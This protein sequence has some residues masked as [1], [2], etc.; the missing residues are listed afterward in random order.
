MSNL[1]QF[2]RVEC[3][4]RRPSILKKEN[5]GEGAPWSLRDVL[6]EVTRQP[7]HHPHVRDPLPPVLLHGRPAQEVVELAEWRAGV[8][9]DAVDRHVRMDAPIAVC[10]VVSYP[11][12]WEEVRASP[13][14]T[15]VYDAWRDRSVEFL[16]QRTGGLIDSILLHEDEPYP[17]L[18]GLGAVPLVPG[19]T[20]KGKAIQRLEIGALD[21]ARTARDQAERAGKPAGEAARAAYRDLAFAYSV[22]V[23]LETGLRMPGL[24]GFGRRRLSSAGH[25]K[26]HAREGGAEPA[27][28]PVRPDLS[29]DRMLVARAALARLQAIPDLRAPAE[30]LSP[31]GFIDL[32]PAGTV[33]RGRVL[34]PVRRARENDR[35]DEAAEAFLDAQARQKVEAEAAIRRADDA[36]VRLAAAEPQASRL[37]RLLEA[38]SAAGPFAGQIADALEPVAP[39]AAGVVRRLGAALTGAVKDRDTAQEEAQRERERNARL[40]EETAE[41]KAAQAEAE[42]RWRALELLDGSEVDLD[43]RLGKLAAVIPRTAALARQ[44]LASSRKTVDDLRAKLSR[45][46][47]AKEQVERQLA[48]A[49]SGAQARAEAVRTIEAIRSAD[50]LSKSQGPAPVLAALGSLAPVLV[51]N[52]KRLRNRPASA[53]AG[54]AEGRR[55]LAAIEAEGAAL[56]LGPDGE[57]DRAGVPAAR[58]D[59]LVGHEA[60]LTL[61]VRERS[62]KAQLAALVKE[63]AVQDKVRAG[64]ARELERAGQAI[65]ARIS[66]GT[67]LEP[68]DNAVGVL[69]GKQ[70]GGSPP[71]GTSTLP[72]TATATRPSLQWLIVDRAIDDARAGRQ[73]MA[74]LPD[75]PQTRA[76]YQDTRQKIARGT[77]ALRRLE[78]PAT[79]T[80]FERHLIGPVIMERQ[81]MLVA[82]PP[83]RLHLI[84]GRSSTRGDTNAHIQSRPASSAATR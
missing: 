39:G 16:V 42:K 32:L 8:A 3:L 52:I 58:Q 17:H 68:V 47:R 10:W 76:L 22:A 9:R 55:R 5:R 79:R 82:L 73:G 84:R 24:E 34:V 41:A 54:L 2:V 1:E 78:D 62:A 77:D 43:G 26:M 30:R 56:T 15:A 48:E 18:H 63:K 50:A 19:E 66:G 36:E 46:V 6:G 65:P 53:D 29:A 7:G 75:S 71:I 31:D 67:T 80:A 27:K 64:T 70:A 72:K 45:E 23:G 74:G 4:A 44:G 13:A 11:L 57:I 12:T 20:N 25:K 40:S 69:G 21:P 14:A 51:S 35:A 61:L 49:Q 33:E 83:E 38:L 37:N 59:F 81:A 60:V 28:K